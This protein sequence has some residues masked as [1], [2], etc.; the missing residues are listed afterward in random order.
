MACEGRDSVASDWNNGRAKPFS[1]SSVFQFF[2]SDAFAAWMF[3][4]YTPA[5]RMGL[6]ASIKQSWEWPVLAGN[7]TQLCLRGASATAHSGQYAPG[8][9]LVFFQSVMRW[10]QMSAPQTL[11]Q[12]EQP[13]GAPL[14]SR[15]PPAVT[16]STAC[17]MGTCG[18]VSLETRSTMSNP[19]GL[20]AGKWPRLPK[21]IR[22]QCSIEYCEA[23]KKPKKQNSSTTVTFWIIAGT[24]ETSGDLIRFF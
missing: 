20:A 13:H 1:S 24:W 6:S 5:H 18:N 3:L 19:K 2:R 15:L 22:R 17:L 16:C 23:N 12:W 9:L 21:F 4:L 11:P 8:W 10:L 14:L 7:A